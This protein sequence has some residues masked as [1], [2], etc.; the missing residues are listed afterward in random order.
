[1][2]SAKTVHSSFFFFP[3]RRLSAFLWERLESNYS[4][5]MVKRDARVLSVEFRARENHARRSPACQQS[6]ENGHHEMR[7]SESSRESLGHHA[8]VK[9]LTGQRKKEIDRMCTCVCVFARKVFCAN[10]Q[11]KLFSIAI[12]TFP[13]GHCRAHKV[14][15]MIHKRQGKN[16]K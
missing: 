5:A 14:F 11:E 10:N 4:G 2:S 1:M 13:I 7:L 6:N 15:F 9:S 12:G 16:R 3:R 8:R